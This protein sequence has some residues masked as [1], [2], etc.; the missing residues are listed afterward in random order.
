VPER[1]DK[2]LSGHKTRSVFIAR[3]HI[4]SPGDLQE[5]ARRLAGRIPGTVD[6]ANVDTRSATP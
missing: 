3:D 4:V 1:V 6:A 2:T 5:A